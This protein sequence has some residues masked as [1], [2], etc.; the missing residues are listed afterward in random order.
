MQEQK[1]EQ[2]QKQEQEKQWVFFCKDGYETAPMSCTSEIAYDDNEHCIIHKKIT[3]IK[4]KNIDIYVTYKNKDGKG[5]WEFLRGFLYKNNNEY[6][7][8][9]FVLFSSLQRGAFCFDRAAI[10]TYC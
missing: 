10:C 4:S 3:S 9:S 7:I 8:S 2:K 1:Q 5:N 6:I